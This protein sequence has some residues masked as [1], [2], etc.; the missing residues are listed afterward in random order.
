MNFAQLCVM[1]GLFAVSFSQQVDAEEYRQV[2]PY[3]GLALGQGNFRF[4]IN[5]VPLSGV[6][7]APEV[8]V[9][10]A[11]PTI[12]RSNSAFK[13]YAGVRVTRYFSL[14]LSRV[15]LGNSRMLMSRRITC[16]PPQ[17]GC[18]PSNP[19][20]SGHV[21]LDGLGLSL[22]GEIPITNSMAFNAR[23][24]RIRSKVTSSLD[25]E[26]V[27]FKPEPHSVR[28]TRPSFGVGGRYT[29]DARVSVQL[30]WEKFMRVGIGNSDQALVGNGS[31]ELTSLGLEYTF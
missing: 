20:Q 12:D 11:Q 28:K 1:A 6:A 26:S 8:G 7:S 31:A 15:D 24:G 25:Q 3:A 30:T 22:V 9:S 2:T 14:E 27:L 10:Q 21:R 23:V 18:V 5:D 16:T 13:L 29:F 19:A 17:L 4:S